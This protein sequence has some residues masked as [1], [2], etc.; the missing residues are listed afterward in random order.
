[1]VNPELV[2]AGESD[3]APSDRPDWDPDYEMYVHSHFSEPGD[4]L[5]KEGLESLTTSTFEIVR[6]L[7]E[8]R[9]LGPDKESTEK[10]LLAAVVRLQAAELEASERESS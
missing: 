5:E 4:G 6:M 9:S 7:I 1:M 3:Q 2:G 8:S 10:R